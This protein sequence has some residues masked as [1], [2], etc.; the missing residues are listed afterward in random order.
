MINIRLVKQ[1]EIVMSKG[2][3]RRK[4]DITDKEWQDAWDRIFSNHP[5]DEQ[6]EKIDKALT[7][8]CNDWSGIE[9]DDYGNCLNTINYKGK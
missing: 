3:G 2:S 7:S 6:F 1:G 9:E 4:Q 8:A 5:N